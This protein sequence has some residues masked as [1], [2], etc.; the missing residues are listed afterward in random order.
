MALWQPWGKHLNQ[1]KALG[2]LAQREELAPGYGLLTAFLAQAFTGD[3]NTLLLKALPRP[4]GESFPPGTHLREEFG[5]KVKW[6]LRSEEVG[7]C[8][9]AGPRNVGGAPPPACTSSS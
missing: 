3:P 7:I 1:T 6:Q 4:A 8:F 9:G 5:P 2:A